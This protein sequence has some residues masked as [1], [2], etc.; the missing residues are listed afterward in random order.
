M[1]FTTPNATSQGDH[2]KDAILDH[3]PEDS[4]SELAW[5]PV[6]NHLAVA[7]WDYTVRIYDVTRSV[8]G[9]GKAL[10]SFGG[11][12]LSCAW[13]PDGSKVVGAGADGSARLVDLAGNPTA[14]QAQ[15]VAQHDA[16]VSIVR[17]VQIPNS[18]APIAVT[19][20]WDRTVKYWDLRQSTP[21]GVVECPERVYA[22]D[23]SQGQLLVALAD[24]Q[25]SL[26]NLSQ[27]T[28]VFKSLQSPLK[29]QTRTICWIPDGSGF[30]V[31]SIEG[32]CGISYIDDAKK[33]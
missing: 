15:Q 13:S 3:P 9:E 4:I 8:K 28:T 6:V 19:G 1:A 33:Q 16:P 22:M 29:H 12:V 24:R 11:P 14:A 32:R 20:S 26:I 21:L 23:I 27:P 17:M 10:F 18:Q 31:G 25:I 5:S 2:S 30:A 7:S